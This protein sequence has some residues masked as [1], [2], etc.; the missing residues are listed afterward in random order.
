MD[1]SDRIILFHRTS[2]ID[3]FSRRHAS[4]PCLRPL[5]TCEKNLIENCIFGPSASSYA[6]K[7]RLGEC[8]HIGMNGKLI[9]SVKPFQGTPCALQLPHFLII[10][11]PFQLTNG[12][13]IKRLPF[14]SLMSNSP[15]FTY[16]V[17]VIHM[18]KDGTN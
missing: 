14:W 10:K 8:R 7:R 12:Q 4:I 18:M 17:Y 9:E 2:S 11:L 15:T 3:S 1:V 5:P 16:T 13:V 6:L